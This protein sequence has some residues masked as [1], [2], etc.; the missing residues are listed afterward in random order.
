MADI[1]GEIGSAAGKVWAAVGGPGKTATLTDIKKKTALDETV[2]AMALGWLA[3]ED[4]VA[5]DKK[6]TVISVKIK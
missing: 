6:G 1:W 4:K 3:R 5:L 2:I